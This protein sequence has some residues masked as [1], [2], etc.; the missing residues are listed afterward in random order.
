MLQKISARLHIPPEML[1]EELRSFLVITFGTL[2]YCVG[3]VFFIKPASLPNTGVMGICLFL[4]YLFNIPLGVSNAL[5]N[6]VLFA[7]AYKYLPKR[8]FYWTLYSSML[9]SLGM[10]LFELFP[11]PVIDDKILQ[12]IIAGVI[13][14][15]SM[16]LVF[17]R[18][19]S[20]GGTD[21]I[22]VAIKRKTGIELGNIT[23]AINFCV[24]LLFFFAVPLVNVIY[25]LLLA[26]LT[27]LVLNDDLRSFASRQEVMIVTNNIEIVRNYIV[28]TLHRGVTLFP[29]RGGFNSE[30]REVIMTLLTRR[31]SIRLKFF[32]KEND[33]EAFMRI[34]V[35]SQVLG[36]G[37]AHW[38]D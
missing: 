19:S 9:L 27:S 7:F 17:S 14:G 12:V 2:L 34:S 5:F 30:P 10:E 23:M 21:I 31:E 13:H 36:K 25:G 4:N 8:F 16:A 29:A 11:K 24:I 22:T 37:F 20:T 3:T 15:I 32:L 33:P 35:A 38:D 18:G 26:Y 6:I 28:Y 1:Q